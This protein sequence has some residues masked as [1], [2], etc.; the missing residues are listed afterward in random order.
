MLQYTELSLAP[1]TKETGEPCAVNY[2]ML[3]N[4]HQWK[5]IAEIKKKLTLQKTMQ[6][7]CFI[8]CRA[9]AWILPKLAASA[10]FLF[11]HNKVEFYDGDAAK[12]PALMEEDMRSVVNKAHQ[13]L[14]TP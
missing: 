13:C 11:L 1:L 12:H 14:W 10:Y 9:I 2:V 4:G 3:V 5:I 6:Y 7:K 8:S